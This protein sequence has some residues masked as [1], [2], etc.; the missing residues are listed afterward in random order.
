MA[1]VFISHSSKDKVIADKMC[2]A[3]EEKGLK[4]WIAPRDITPGT[5]WAVAI[6]DA[7][8]TI[9]VMVVIYSAMCQRN[10]GCQTRGESLLFRIRLTIWSLQVLLIIIWQE[11]TGLWQILRHLTINLMNCMV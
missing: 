8:A 6:S 10:W 11:L 4:C 9:K 7:I 1:D 3:L 2:E 5:E